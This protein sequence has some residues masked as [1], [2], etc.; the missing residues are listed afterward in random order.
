MFSQALNKERAAM[1]NEELINDWFDLYTQVLENY[2]LQSSD[3]YNMNKKSFIMKIMSKCKVIYF[4]EQL[5]TM[6]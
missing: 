6:T 2:D 5:S 4:K 3:I 1:H